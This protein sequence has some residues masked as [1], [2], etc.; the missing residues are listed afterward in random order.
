MP[1]KRNYRRVRIEKGKPLPDGPLE[2]DECV[3]GPKNRAWRWFYSIVGPIMVLAAAYRRVL[4]NVSHLS[5]RDLGM[6]RY[7]GNLRAEYQLQATQVLYSAQGMGYI[8]M[9]LGHCVCDPGVGHKAPRKKPKERG[10]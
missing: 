3:L 8:G 2:Q 9:K 5:M 4:R 7:I 6:G 10:Q 1:K